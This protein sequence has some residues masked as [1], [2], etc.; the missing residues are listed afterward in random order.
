MKNGWFCITIEWD[1]DK[2][3]TL[4]I[5]DEN[6]ALAVRDDLLTNKHVKKVHYSGEKEKLDKKQKD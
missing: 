5:K 1:N 6:V 4:W 2:I 3:Q